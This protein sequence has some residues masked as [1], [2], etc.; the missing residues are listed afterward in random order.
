VLQRPLDTLIPINQH[1][2]RSIHNILNL[3]RHYMN[4]SYLIIEALSNIAANFAHFGI[5]LDHK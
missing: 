1:V 3:S 2:E 4:S 5:N